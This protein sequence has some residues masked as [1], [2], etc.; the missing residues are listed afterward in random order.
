[1]PNKFYFN[2]N[3]LIKKINLETE[4]VLLKIGYMIEA[5]A[6][7]GM[8]V[9]GQKDVEYKSNPLKNLKSK[10]KKDRITRKEKITKKLASTKSNERKITRAAFLLKE[11]KIREVED[12]QLGKRK[13]RY[14]KRKKM[15]RISVPSDPGNPPNVQ[16]GNLKSSISTAQLENGN[17]VVG[18][19]AKYGGLHEFGGTVK[20]RKYPKRPF[21]FPAWRR[22]QKKI[23]K[24]FKD[25]LK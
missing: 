9:G 15:R 10:I 12:N 25:C 22:V 13:D 17:V 21:M 7:K 6:K 2:A 14:G 1:L 23:M 5:E 11:S 18:P 19:T 16:T 8:K 20:G 3:A 4:K 24:L